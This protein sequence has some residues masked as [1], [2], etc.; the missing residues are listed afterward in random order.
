MFD[1]FYEFTWLNLLSILAFFTTVGL[2]FCGIPICRQIWKRKDTTEISGAPFIMGVLGGTCWM[3]Y[4]YL[5]KDD[6]VIY[7]TSAQIILYAIYVVFFFFMTKKKFWISI[8]IIALVSIC[9][10]LIL[11]VHFFGH[12]VFHPLGIVCMVL[13][14]ADFGAPLAGLRVVIRR[15]AT[16][17]LPLP[18][19]IANFLV[20]SEWFLYGLLVWD[21]Y[22]ITP[23]G[24]G[25]FLAFCQL[26][27]FVVLPR[28][29]N[30]RAPFLQLY[31][32][33]RSCGI[34]KAPRTLSQQQL[35]RRVVANMAGEI[36][37]VI[38]KV[39]LADQFAY[40]NKLSKAGQEETGS[41]T[42]SVTLTPENAGTP[43]DSN[44]DIVFPM[45]IRDE[46]QL[47]QLSRKLSSMSTQ[48]EHQSKLN[49][50]FGGSSNGWPVSFS[51]SVNIQ[52]GSK[53]YSPFEGSC[54]GGMM[55]SPHPVG[56][57]EEEEGEMD[58]WNGNRVH[59]K[60]QIKRC[61]SAPELSED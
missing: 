12:K 61:R 13:N 39:H 19:C 47:M 5:K 9:S 29:P 41:T 26:V 17:T 56:T 45:T 7:V 34:S 18:L 22:L 55:P 8:Q 1:I 21:F 36:E 38:Q 20:S 33:F 25:S 52:P 14:I 4:G 53:L 15:K 24:I 51:Q 54:N 27:L 40:S 11:S 28:K 50:G 10:A 48:P 46:R 44:K 49:G 42:G 32:F 2:F 57:I 3:T 31:D 59:L 58:Q 60:K 43:T 30:Q 16:S 37:N 6:T 35:F 23:N